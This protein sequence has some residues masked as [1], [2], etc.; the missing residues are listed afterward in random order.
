MSVRTI[1]TATLMLAVLH[2]SADHCSAARYY[3]RKGGNDR[4]A[5]TSRST[6]WKTLTR[7]SQQQLSAGDVVYVGAGVYTEPFTPNGGG[8]N[9]R[10]AR[11]FGDTRGRYTGNRGAVVFAPRR[12]QWHTRL[13]R[14]GALRFDNVTFDSR[15]G[16]RA[17]QGYGVYSPRGSAVVQ[18][19]S[20]RF[21]RVRYGAWSSAQPLHFYNCRFR[22][23]TGADVLLQRQASGLLRSCI[24]DHSRA[25]GSG[26]ILYHQAS[27][28]LNGCRF[29]AGRFGVLSNGDTDIT[30]NRCAFTRSQYPVYGKAKSAS[31]TATSVNRAASGVYLNSTGQ[32]TRINRVRVS[33]SQI[34]L[35]VPVSGYDLSSVT[36]DRNRIALW[37]HPLLPRFELQKNARVTL[38]SNQYGLYLPNHNRAVGT[39]VV[40]RGLT[41]S[42]HTQ[43]AVLAYKADLS[44]RDCRFTGNRY[45]VYAASARSCEIRNT[46]FDR[47]RSG[48]AVVATGRNID[49]RD[50]NLSSNAHGLYLRPASNTA[51]NLQNVSISGSRMGL[52]VD[53]GQFRISDA[54]Q[55]TLANNTTGMLLMGTDAEI[56]GVTLRGGGIGIDVRRGKV[57]L[58]DVT[59]S[60]SGY[61]VIARSVT[62]LTASGL[63]SSGNRSWGLHA[64]GNTIQ[65]EKSTFDRNRNGVY[66]QESGRDR[67]V[68][69]S[70]SRI[71]NSRGYGLLFSQCSL[72]GNADLNLT[73]QNNRGAGITVMGRPLS[74]TSQKKVDI[75]GNGTGIY[76]VGSPLSLSG[77]NLNNNRF[78]VRSSGGNIMCKDVAISGGAYGIYQTNAAEC[79]LSDSSITR[80]S[81]YAL[82]VSNRRVA[83]Q[84]VSLTNVTMTRNRTAA[85]VNSRTD[86]S[87][88]V[89]DCD[90][91]QNSGHGLL[92]YRATAKVSGSTISSNR[93]YGVL[94]IDGPLS[95]ADSSLSN[96]R[97]YAIRVYSQRNTSGTTLG[98]RNCRLQNNN[99]GV[100][101]LRVKSAEITNNVVTGNRYG[102]ISHSAV[103]PV[104]VWNN[105]IADNQ[106]GVYHSGGQAQVV[107]NIISNGD[108]T[109]ADQNAWGIYYKSG[110]LTHRHNLLFGQTRK[111]LRTKPGSGDVIKPPRFRD[112]PGGDFRLAMGSPAIN[113]GTQSK[114]VIDDANG[115]SRPLHGAHEIGAYEFP[116]KAGSVRILDWQEVAAG[117]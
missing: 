51:P 77:I 48:W 66:L 14:A 114:L 106:I 6:A 70:D 85:Y 90:F 116:E 89:T 105:T 52:R 101:T 24:V 28:S 46:P 34:G 11:I 36:L 22:S 100:G 103:H 39:D 72:A 108:M 75:S 102:V 62:E 49:I 95:V 1:L 27:V 47:N 25:N 37:V 92:S 18:F 79:V 107:N 55:V 110:T 71:T 113:S 91:S 35:Q 10:P 12:G 57:K 117:P 98:V 15:T 96:N 109:D 45:G 88:T 93:A 60:N 29:T 99:V 78:G 30:I 44:V 59:V 73:V 86:G 4:S 81:S 20:C 63:T 43:Y 23:T 104:E 80:A 8:T 64:T 3:V 87:V 50:C 26:I 2:V 21:Q 111:Y 41:F 42:G 115:V 94:H 74:L 97:Q 82:V 65:V 7:L 112:R 61:G 53:G 58:R 76:S 5:G 17:S 9:G 31:I 54:S 56:T 32:P 19:V 16:S 33:S 68:P 69:V 38:Q 40:L 13:T 84:R 83:R 67:Q